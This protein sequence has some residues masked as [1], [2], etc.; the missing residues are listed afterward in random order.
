MTSCNAE[1]MLCF[2][3]I[4]MCDV[5]EADELMH[6]FRCPLQGKDEFLGRCIVKPYIR[7]E[8]PH[9]PPK[10]DWYPITYFGKDAG[11]ILAAFHLMVV[12][13]ALVSDQIPFDCL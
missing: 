13:Y 3:K 1:C 7:C 12:R 5:L 11:E 10:L 4:T 8:S 6:E 9:P 2:E